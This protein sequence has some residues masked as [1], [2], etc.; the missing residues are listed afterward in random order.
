ME[1]SVGDHVEES[2]PNGI[3]YFALYH[4]ITAFIDAVRGHTK[5]R[6]DRVYASQL[7]IRMSLQSYL[8]VWVKCGMRYFAELKC[9]INLR[10][11]RVK[12]GMKNAEYWLVIL[13]K[14][15]KKTLYLNV[16]FGELSKSIIIT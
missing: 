8:R 5:N 6:Q 4:I 10:N 2:I 15:P 9:G 7:A 16:I 12:C 1:S 3:A 11:G 14:I 13:A